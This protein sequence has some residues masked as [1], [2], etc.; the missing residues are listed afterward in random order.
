MA[1]RNERKNSRKVAL[2]REFIM[3]VFKAFK[4]TSTPWRIFV[5]SSVFVTQH[6]IDE[7][8]VSDELRKRIVNFFYSHE[9]VG[10]FVYFVMCFIFSLFKFLKIISHAHTCA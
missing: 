5:D 6:Q 3:Q 7:V 1:A 10:L 8:Y 4:C 2:K 9:I